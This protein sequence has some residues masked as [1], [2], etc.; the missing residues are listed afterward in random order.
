MEVRKGGVWVSMT[1]A[2]L[3]TMATQNANAVAITGGAISGLGNVVDAYGF[4]VANHAGNSLIGFSSGLMAAGGTGRYGVNCSGDAPN[5][6][7]GNLG[8]GHTPSNARLT[9][10]YPRAGGDNGLEVRPSA[11]SGGSAIVF[12]NASAAVVGYISTTPTATVYSTSSDARLRHSITPLT[13]A[14]ST[15][16]ALSPV[17]FRWNVNDSEDEGFLAHELQVQVPHAVTGEPDQVNDDGSIRPQGVDHSKL[18]PWLT[19]A[20]KELAAQVQALTAR[21]VALEAALP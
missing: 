21:V 5:F 6:L 12:F 13:D 9:L 4:T 8:I 3:G 18:V 10:G 20:C 11:D 16:T 15:L 17:R 19:A 1:G 7:G 2:T 14:L